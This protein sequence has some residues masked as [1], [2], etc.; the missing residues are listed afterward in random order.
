MYFPLQYL[1]NK[2]AAKAAP[3][4]TQAFPVIIAIP[5]VLVLDV[6]EVCCAPA[7]PD[8]ELEVCVVIEEDPDDFVDPAGPVL[9][10]VPGPVVLAG[11]ASIANFEVV[12]VAV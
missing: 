9:L 7:G 4:I 2:A 8:P 3:P 12:R 10:A 11:A 1:Y 6:E 5:P